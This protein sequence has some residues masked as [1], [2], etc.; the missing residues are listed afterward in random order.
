[1]KAIVEEMFILEDK[2]NV[3]LVVEMENFD[4]QDQALRIILIYRSDEDERRIPL[5]NLIIRPEEEGGAIVYGS[6]AYDIERLFWDTSWDH[7]TLEIEVAY[8]NMNYKAIPVELVQD[9]KIVKK[10]GD[11]TLRIDCGEYRNIYKRDYA[12]PHIFLI[13]LLRML[14]MLIGVLS[15]PLFFL[16]GLAAYLPGY[17]IERKIDG[18]TK[19]AR[20][21]KYVGRRYFRFSGLTKGVVGFYEDIMRLTYHLASSVFIKK[22]GI[23]IVSNRR[24]D[25][26]GNFQ[27]VY[28]QIKEDPV[29]IRFW[30]RD[31]EP[32]ECGLL[33]QIDLSLKA[34]RSKIIL[35]DDFIPILS[36]LKLSG[37][38]KVLQLW[39]ACGSFKTFGFSRLGK[40]G[41]PNQRDEAHRIYDGVFVSSTDVCKNYSE[42]FGVREEKVFPYGIPRT[43]VF[44]DSSCRAAMKDKVYGQYPMLKDKKVIL[45]APTFRG[46]GKQ[47]AYYEKT[48]F[49]PNEFI[50]SLP[51]DYVLLIKHHPFVSLKYKIKKTNRDRIFD[52]SAESEINDLLF[53]TDILI[54]DYS[55]VIYEAS[56]LNI[57]ML[58]Y[59]Y[60]QEAYLATRDFYPGFSGFVPG[61]IVRTQEELTKLILDKDFDQEKVE[62]FCHENFDNRDGKSSQRIADY[63]R[64]I[65]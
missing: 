27:Y 19:G 14:N 51:D 49:R 53:I 41:A 23:L 5:P 52:F 34:A 46:N 17:D 8:Q 35:V 57:P 3:S 20:L 61:K 28:D 33:A 54:T 6:Y 59:A 44:F 24:T 30:L 47:S 1:M 65:L 56:I 48:A 18:K 60:D 11:S 32:V 21:I 7:F 63:I 45:F 58:F 4:P 9:I 26:T 15:L 2:L 16:T 25:L 39:H 13:F 37:K 22:K 64:K 43:D 29:P 38:T 10:T 12:F 55:S 62:K 42:G 40:K 50:E 31:R 36:V